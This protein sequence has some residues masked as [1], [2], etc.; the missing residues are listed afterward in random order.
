MVLLTSADWKPS[1]QGLLQRNGC[2]QT[3]LG[4]KL[5]AELGNVD[6]S[7]RVQASIYERGTSPY[8]ESTPITYGSGGLDSYICCAMLPLVSLVQAITT[9]K[10]AFK[11]VDTALPDEH[12][13]RNQF[14]PQPHALAL[15]PSLMLRCPYTPLACVRSTDDKQLF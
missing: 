9:A 1:G 10:P 12:F 14:C 3:V 6:A 2:E 5:T 13:E 7:K 11:S 15:P 4:R 8:A